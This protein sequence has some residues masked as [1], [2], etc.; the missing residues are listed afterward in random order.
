MI[1]GFTGHR[2]VSLPGKY[3]EHTERALLSTADFILAQYKPEKVI[4][5]M[6]LGW[7]TAVAESAVNRGISLI[8]AVPFESQPSRWPKSSQDRYQRLL[9]KAERIEIISSGSYSLEA[10]QLRNQWIVNY[11]DR[12]IALWHQ[13]KSGTK[14]CVDYALTINRPTFNCWATFGY[15]YDRC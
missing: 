6:A 7:D 8:A 11:C 5:G 15:F 2:P 4:S 3:S 9:N 12:L 1:L 10:M 13:G 14:S